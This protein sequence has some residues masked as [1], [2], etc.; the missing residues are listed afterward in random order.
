M[1]GISAVELIGRPFEQLLTVPARLLFQ[2]HVFPA[3]A[4][5]GRVE[6]VF[7]TLRDG[8]EAAIPVLMNAVRSIGGRAQVYSAVL[9]RIRARSQWEND[10]LV[11]TGALEG[12]RQAS[13]ALSADLATMAH[14]LEARLADDRRSRT[15]RDAFVGVVSHELRTPITTIFGMSHLLRQRHGSM[16]PAAV[17][18]ALEDIESEAE[19]L[20]RLT[21]DLLVLSRAEAGRLEVA[22]EPL[23]IG[24]LLRTVVSAEGARAEGHSFELAIDPYLPIVSGEETYVEQVLR[25]FLN[26]AVKYSP[27]GSV[28]RADA[29]RED[30]GVAVRVIDE[31]VGFGDEPPDHLWELFFRTD[32]A[33]R[34]ASGAGIGLFVSRELINA[35]GGRVWAKAARRQGGGA[36]FGFWLPAAEV[37]EDA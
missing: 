7:L 33:R 19:R 37:D 9:V 30:E 17:T 3:L 12:E 23:L 6:E 36:E 24:H 28:V 13:R 29:R 14:D 27:A 15:F 25:N 32:D 31:G 8:G 16:D 22:L 5:D 18:A 34:Q 21:E 20:R 10:L 4:A 35:M 11:A 2:T 1:V 26:N